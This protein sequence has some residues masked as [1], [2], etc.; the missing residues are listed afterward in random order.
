MIGHHDHLEGDQPILV[1]RVQSL[2]KAVDELESRGWHSDRTLEIPQGPC[3]SFRTL[4]GHRLAVYEI[5]RPGV[6]ASFE[7]RQDF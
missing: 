3:R 2:Q 5:S 7:G 4:G 6:E 1:Y